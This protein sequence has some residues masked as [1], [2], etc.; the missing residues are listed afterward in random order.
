SASAFIA[1]A[2]V[3]ASGNAVTKIVGMRSPLAISRACRS[4]P[5]ERPN[6][7][8]ASGRAPDGATL[9]GLEAN[10]RALIAGFQRVLSRSD[11]DHHRSIRLNF[12][13]SRLRLYI[14]PS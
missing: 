3:V 11:Y 2:R 14:R 7:P 4:S 13:P 5:I 8:C 10:F 9:L 12:E 6:C 1:R